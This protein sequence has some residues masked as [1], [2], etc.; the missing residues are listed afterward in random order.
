MTVSPANNVAAVNTVS[1]S[2]MCIA[3][4]RPAQHRGQAVTLGI[5][6]LAR[7]TPLPPD[8]ISR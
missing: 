6:L 3:R 1:R 7:T 5:S 4:F 2:A 8:V